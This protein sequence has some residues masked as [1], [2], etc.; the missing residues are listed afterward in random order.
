MIPLILILN[1]IIPNQVPGGQVEKWRKG[2]MGTRSS[3]ITRKTPSLKPAWTGL[4]AKQ[5]KH[6]VLVIKKHNKV[7]STLKLSSTPAQIMKAI[8]VLKWG[9]KKKGVYTSSKALNGAKCYAL[10]RQLGIP[11]KLGPYKHKSAMKYPVSLP[12]KLIG[13]IYYRW[14][15]GSKPALVFNCRMVVALY[16]AAPIF[17]KHGFD[18]IIYTSTFR[19]TRVAG[20]RRLSRHAY[21]MAIDIKAMRGPGGLVAVIE[22]DWMR[23]AGTKQSCVGPLPPGVPRTMRQLICDFEKYPIFRRILTP[24]YDHGHRDHFHIS[25]TYPG[26]RWRRRRYAGKPLKRRLST[27]YH[28]KRLPHKLPRRP[29]I[30]TKTLKKHILPKKLILPTIKIPIPTK[31]N[32]QV[33]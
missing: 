1:F 29:A 16:L 21:G 9:N 25:G 12:N 26:E 20:K 5:Q 18:E 32:I 2:W 31:P 17:K 33:D 13:G 7:I 10:L 3:R 23:I 22:R 6:K 27:Y 4:S 15:W 11:F 14:A 24:D 8:R 19:Y 30:F 28:K